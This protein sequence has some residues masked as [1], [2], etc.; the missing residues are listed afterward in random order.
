MWQPLQITT[1]A[2]RHLKK[3]THSRIP[4]DATGIVFVGS[5]KRPA[6]NVFEIC[7]VLIFNPYATVNL[8]RGSL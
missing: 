3:H 6:A 2:T 5:E 8:H 4:Q 1:I 7:T